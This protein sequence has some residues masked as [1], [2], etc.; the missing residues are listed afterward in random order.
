M[1]MNP[2]PSARLSVKVVSGSSRD[3]IVGWLGD[4]L[5]IKVTSP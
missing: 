4:A 3:G 5:K 2:P 1:T